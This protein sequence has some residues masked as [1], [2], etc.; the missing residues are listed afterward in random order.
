MVLTCDPLHVAAGDGLAHV[1][2][3]VGAQAVS[4]DVEVL[5]LQQLL[6]DEEV[7]EAGDLL[8]HPLDVGAGLDVKRL[9]A[10]LAPVHRDHVVVAV[11]QQPCVRAGPQ[12][13]EGSGQDLTQ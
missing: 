2:G 13:Q 5:R 1:A 4:E 10:E 7:D 11:R 6:G 12:G 8:P 9:R 3:D